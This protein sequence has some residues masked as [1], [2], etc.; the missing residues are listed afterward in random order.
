MGAVSRNW[1]EAYRT[2][3]NITAFKHRDIKNPIYV[4]SWYSLYNAV[5]RITLHVAPPEVGNWHIN[6][7]HWRIETRADGTAYWKRVRSSTVDGS[8]VGYLEH[9][10]ESDP[11]PPVAWRGDKQMSFVRTAGGVVHITLGDRIPGAGVVGRILA[12]KDPFPCYAVE[13]QRVRVPRHDNYPLFRYMSI[14]Q[15]DVESAGRV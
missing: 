14:P 6:V 12:T 9:S 11:A 4:G 13:V 15:C 3:H 8:C 7:Y 1:A 2:E 10:L 5:A